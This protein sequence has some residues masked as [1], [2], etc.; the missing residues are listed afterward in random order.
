VVDSAE[1]VMEP[2]IAED[3]AGLSEVETSEVDVVDADAD[4]AATTPASDWASHNKAPYTV[5]VGTCTTVHVGLA[6]F[7]VVTRLVVGV[8]VT[9]DTVEV[10][11]HDSH[12]P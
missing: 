12:H 4:A 11:V 8:P 10:V 2:E 6:A 1:V 9:V 7:V 5:S 3:V